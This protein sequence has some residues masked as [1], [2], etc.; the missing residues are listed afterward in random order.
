MPSDRPSELM[1]KA[2]EE[3]EGIRALRS[4]SVAAWLIGF[5]CQQA[6]EKALKAVLIGKGVNPGYVHDLVALTRQLKLAGVE[7]PEWLSEVEDLNPFAVQLRYET[8]HAIVDFDTRHAEQLVQRVCVWARAELGWAPHDV[9][10]GFDPEI[11]RPEHQSG[12]AEG[13]ESGEGDHFD[14]GL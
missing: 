8:L 11:P 2:E 14:M 13:D 5:H 7:E 12:A 9:F 10:G 1:E 6:V 4:G 3:L